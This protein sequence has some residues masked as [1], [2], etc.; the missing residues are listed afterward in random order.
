MRLTLK[1][2]NCICMISCRCSWPVDRLRHLII[3]IEES[4]CILVASIFILRM[5]ITKY[6]VG[7]IIT[8]TIQLIND[9]GLTT[10]FLNIQFDMS[11]D[12]TTL[13]VTTE[14]LTEITIGD[15]HFY[16]T[17]HICI[18][19]TT[20]VFQ[21]LLVWLTIQDGNDVT[22]NISISTCIIDL[23]YLQCTSITYLCGL[24]RNLALDGT[25]LI[26]CT[27]QFVDI[28]TFYRRISI[29]CTVSD[30]SCAIVIY[31]DISTRII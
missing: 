23:V 26:T 13:V 22:F 6:R 18:L 1:R 8:T 11:E 16:I 31:T 27:E 3:I 28:T 2:N 4:V 7:C 17:L 20:I 14:D 30:I 12:S 19:C 10:C 24:E 15:G 25:L 21:D 5:V 29:T 9:N